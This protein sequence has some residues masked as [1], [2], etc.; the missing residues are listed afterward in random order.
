MVGLNIDRGQ[1]QQRPDT[2]PL[3]VDLEYTGIHPIK[4]LI[5]WK[6]ITTPEERNYPKRDKR[7]RRKT[8]GWFVPLIVIPPS[9]HLIV[10]T[11]LSLPME[12]LFILFFTTWKRIHIYIGVIF[13]SLL[14]SWNWRRMLLSWVAPA[15]A[16]TA[17]EPHGSDLSPSLTNPQPDAVNELKQEL[18]QL[19]HGSDLS[20]SSTN[21]HP[22]A[23]NESKQELV[24]LPGKDKNL[25]SSQA[26]LVKSE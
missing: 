8:L 3:Q 15:V 12:T 25:S 6:G 10:S 19:P 4:H 17:C 13:R 9:S 24:Q 14:Y 1:P 26:F 11:P 23:V 21:T 7:W 22:V 18:V 2:L 16:Y 5:V 20:P